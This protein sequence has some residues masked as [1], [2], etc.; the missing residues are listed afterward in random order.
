MEHKAWAGNTIGGSEQKFVPLADHHSASSQS[1]LM[2]INV[3][4][5][6]DFRS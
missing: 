4:R 3:T 1:E 2:H 6:Y 5:E